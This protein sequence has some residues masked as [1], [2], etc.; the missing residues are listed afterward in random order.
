MFMNCQIFLNIY[1]SAKYFPIN[2]KPVQPAC[3]L[4]TYQFPQLIVQTD[5]QSDQGGI[6]F[7][8]SCSYFFFH[9]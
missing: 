9:K 1:E 2:L 7:I 3:H 5:T 8:L 6:F 4:T